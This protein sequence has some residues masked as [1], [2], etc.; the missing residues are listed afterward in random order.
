M[1]LLSSIVY[2]CLLVF[3]PFIYISDCSNTT[4]TYD[5]G[6]I[7]S[8][9]EYQLRRQLVSNSSRQTQHTPALVAPQSPAQCH[10]MPRSVD[11]VDGQPKQESPITVDLA[12]LKLLDR[13]ILRMTQS[14]DPNGESSG[15]KSLRQRSLK[16]AFKMQTEENDQIAHKHQPDVI[17]AQRDAITK[18][19]KVNPLVVAV[20]GLLTSVYNVLSSM[21]SLSMVHIQSL[22]FKILLISKA[23][24]QASTQVD[25][26][27]LLAIDFILLVT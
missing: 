4:E 26:S 15:E 7:A 8:D 13:S 1:S 10:Y 22:P 17:A 20:N 16:S 9:R 6:P 11:S 2:E 25:P 12:K 3:I 24:L 21:Q 27:K 5:A 23:Q 19:T 14:I 18:N